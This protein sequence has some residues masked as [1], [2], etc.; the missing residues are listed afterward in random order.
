MTPQK[1]GEQ[2]PTITINALPAGRKNGVHRSGGA[3]GITQECQ[4]AESF[5]F[6]G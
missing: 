5:E 1:I 4:S 6:L 2:W 3:S